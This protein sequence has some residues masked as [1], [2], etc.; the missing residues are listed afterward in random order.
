MR[1]GYRDRA[2]PACR[3]DKVV[4]VPFKTD[5]EWYAQLPTMFGAADPP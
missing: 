5:A 4:S 2:R 1:P 3:P